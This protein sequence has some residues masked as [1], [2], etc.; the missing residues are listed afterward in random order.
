[1]N[2]PLLLRSYHGKSI[3]WRAS[4]KELRQS[5]EKELSVWILPCFWTNSFLPK[6][7]VWSFDVALQI[8]FSFPD[9]ENTVLLQWAKYL[10]PFS[11]VYGW[12]LSRSAVQ[13]FRFPLSQAL[14]FVSS[15]HPA[16]AHSRWYFQSVSLKESPPQQEVSPPG[17]RSVLSVL[18]LYQ[19]CEAV[20][21]CG[22]FLQPRYRK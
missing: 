4:P 1:M 7:T 15:S 22:Y 5:K 2:F 16:A 18:L 19:S 12:Q 14:L 11:Q 17:K 20:H 10:P 9:R 6:K 3:P 21:N 13:R 8:P